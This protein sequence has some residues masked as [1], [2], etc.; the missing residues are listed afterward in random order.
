M[1]R[2]RQVCSEHGCPNLQPCELHARQSWARSDRRASLPADWR[3]RRS[4]VLARDR[5]VCQLRYPGCV[6]RATEVHHLVHRDV[7]D[8]EALAAVCT[9]CHKSATQAEARSA[10]QRRP[11]Q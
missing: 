2:A 7:H 9:S 5:G 10:R 6:V 3:A 11:D 4:A 1:G 8:I